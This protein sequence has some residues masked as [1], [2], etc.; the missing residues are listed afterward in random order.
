MRR[1]LW[2]ENLWWTG[3][4]RAILKILQL[5]RSADCYQT[6]SIPI[7]IVMHLLILGF[8]IIVQTTGAYEKAW[9]LLKVSTA[10]IFNQWYYAEI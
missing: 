5:K 9:D 4:L 1:L 3:F 2:T 10:Y 6:I 7:Y 8:Y